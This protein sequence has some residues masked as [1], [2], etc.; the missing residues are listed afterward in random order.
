MDQTGIDQ[1]I[2]QLVAEALDIHRPSGRKVNQGLL[3]LGRT[4]KA[5]RTTGYRLVDTFLD[6]RTAFRTDRRHSEGR[7]QRLAAEQVAGRPFFRDDGDDFGNHIARPPDDD[8]VADPYILA[9]HF[10]LVVQRRIGHRHA[11]DEDRLQACNWG[12]RPGPPDL[13][14]DAEHFGQ[15]LLGR[16]FV[17]D[18]EAWGPRDETQLRLGRQLVDLVHHAVDVVGQARPLFTN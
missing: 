11:T 12:D 7:M 2:D 17:G 16:K 5:A 6:R 1:L 4:V 13:D 9:P 14:I 15:G 18:G 3:A 8:R 10:V